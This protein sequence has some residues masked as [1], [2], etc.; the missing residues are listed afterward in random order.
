MAKSIEVLITG[1]ES[2][3]GTAVVHAAVNAA[4]ALGLKVSVTQRFEGGSDWLCLYGVGEASRNAAR[5][6]Q[7]ANGGRVAC[8]DLGYIR[9]GKV[10]GASYVR[11][12]IN[13]NH[14]WRDLDFTPNDSARLDELGVLMTEEQDPTGP[15]IVIGMGP[16]S[17]DHLGLQDWEITTLKQARERFP[18]RE[19]LYRPKPRRI[20]DSHIKWKLS[21]GGNIKEALRGAS[22]VVCRHSNVAVD[23]CMQGIPVECEDGAAYW[24][25]QHGS[26]PTL[27]ARTDFMKRLAYW[28]YR[29]D[30]QEAAWKFLLRFE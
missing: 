14:P 5:H 27:E 26:T 15:V 25:Y 7:I 3:I 30:E 16:K 20:M 13:D 21:L 17:R 22:L 29:T 24:L 4:R 8:W 28:Q 19:I 2:H 6:E 9:T 10:P 18:G 1:Q 23:A 11:V 12:S